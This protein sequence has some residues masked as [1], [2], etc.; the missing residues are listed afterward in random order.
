MSQKSGGYATHAPVFG[1]PREKVQQRSKWLSDE[2]ETNPEDAV[3]D[4]LA[5]R[6]ALLLERCREGD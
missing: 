6:V 1:L 5:H 4:R 2:T 3:P